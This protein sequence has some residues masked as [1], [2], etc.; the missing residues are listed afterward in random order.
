MLTEFALNCSS[1][2]GID[3]YSS[4]GGAVSSSGGGGGGGGGHKKLFHN[5]RSAR[6]AR[7]RFLQLNSG[8]KS[9]AAATAPPDLSRMLQTLSVL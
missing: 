3:A 5:A 4:G 1:G 9:V 8:D 6:Q 2:A 7:D